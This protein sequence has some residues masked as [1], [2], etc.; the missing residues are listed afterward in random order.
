MLDQSIH[1]MEIIGTVVEGLLLVRIL[2]LRLHQ[3]YLFV[4]LYA[5]VNLLVDVVSLAVGSESDAAARIFFYSRFVYAVMYPL[6][7]WDVFE[8]IKSHITKLRKLHIPRLASGLFLTALLGLIL[9]MNI[10]DQDLKGTSSSTDFMGLF[11]WVGA[12]S[13]SLL[14]T[15]HVFRTSR[16]QNVVFPR[17]TFV[18]AI[19]F[20]FTFGLAII[21]C[22]FDVAG[23]LLPHT[24]LQV[25][26]LILISCDLSLAAW[27]LVNL[28]PLPPDLS[29]A[30]EKA[31]L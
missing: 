27:C 24:L 31:S 21:D 12:A 6:A 1:W 23:G 5:V 28:K 19:Y 25:A 26:N 11:V 14:F 3:L 16:K 15:W 20:I 13:S 17:N 30:P 8:Q 4:T 22:G 29:S 7:A 2:Q 10:E 9:S 18:W